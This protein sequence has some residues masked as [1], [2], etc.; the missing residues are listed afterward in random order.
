MLLF[1]FDKALFESTATQNLEKGIRLEVKI[2]EIRGAQVNGLIDAFNSGDEFGLWST[3]DEVV[4]FDLTV[5]DLV[6]NVRE[7]FPV[8]VHLLLV[9]VALLHASG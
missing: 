9:G 8:L 1:H 6:R 3:V 2:K 4:R 5:V 7:C